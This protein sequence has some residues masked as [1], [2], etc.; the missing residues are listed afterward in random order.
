MDKY[1]Y[2]KNNSLK[3]SSKIIL[4]KQIIEESS[5]EQMFN[6]YLARMIEDSDSLGH[7]FKNNNSPLED[8]DLKEW[9]GL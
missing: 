9:S 6:E 2:L 3:H 4:N 1:Y 8:S 5:N 7:S